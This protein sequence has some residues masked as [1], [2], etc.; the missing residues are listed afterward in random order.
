MS[1]RRALREMLHGV[2][3]C[4]RF[5]GK[6]LNDSRKAT[7]DHLVPLSR[8]GADDLTNSVV[9]CGRCNSHKGDLLIGEYVELLRWTLQRTESLMAGGG[10]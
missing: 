1:S 5:C 10:A 4:C 2:D 7:L 8:G 3:P 9:S 6:F